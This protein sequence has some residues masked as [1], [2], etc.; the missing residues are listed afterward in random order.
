MINSWDKCSEAL[1]LLIGFYE[2]QV[3]FW[4]KLLPG[5]VKHILMDLQNHY[6]IY[7]DN[8]IVFKFFILHNISTPFPF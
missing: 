5:V 3:T 6:D 1:H 4:S 2:L 7:I 8:T